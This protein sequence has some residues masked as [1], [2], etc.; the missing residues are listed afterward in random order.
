[1]KR[2]I[3]A[4]A[5]LLVLTLSCNWGQRRGVSTPEPEAIVNDTVYPLGFCTDSF[6]RVD[7]TVA[8]GA[9]FSGLMGSLGL[10]GDETYQLIHASEGIFD[11]RRFRAGNSWQAYYSDS[12]KLKY[13]VYQDNRVRSI[14]FQ[15]RDSL[16]AWTYD[17]PVERQEKVADITIH[18]S[19][20]N[21]M[22]D[23]GASPLI[24][25]ELADIYAWTVDFFGLQEGD[26]FRVL[27]N[28]DVCEG[29]VFRIVDVPYAVFSRDG[30]EYPALY[31]DQHDNGN[32]Y[33]NEKGES[34]RKAFL[35]A[36][37]KFSRISSGFS[38][39]RLHPVHGTVR[40]HTGVD[41]AAPTGTPVMSI[42]DGTVISKGWGG[43]G[44]NTVKIRHNSVYTTAYL[45]LSKYAAGLKV[46]D[47]VHQGQ[48]IGYVG[49][50]GTATGPHLD[51]RVWKNGTPIN[52]LKM[53]S[54]S[55]DPIREEFKPPLDSAYRVR[56]Q[57]LD[58]LLVSS[59]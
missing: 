59:K 17:K 36:P 32:K 15:C 56:S 49:M 16:A 39:H 2:N 55:G 45:H 8:A 28:Q 57:R 13:L 54:P 19:L 23:A 51:F 44:G 35:K 20:W 34:M 1:M 18:T 42:G 47:R 25:V 11:V 12:T 33:W 48:V 24:I 26:R 3:A 29:E 52:P 58:S 30:K 4:I 53:E 41:Y 46:G 22:L 9:T 14:V 40:P 43:G 10:T 21:D 7:G 38:Y 37:L 27:Y 5:L 6:R 50:T 31:L